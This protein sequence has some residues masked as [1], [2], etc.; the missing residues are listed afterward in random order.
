MS[1]QDTFAERNRRILD[2]LQR[3]GSLTVDEIVTL[4][5]VSVATVRRDLDV[6]ERDGR[7]RRT[8]GGAIPLEPLLYQAF[9]HDSSFQEQVEH[10]SAEKRR[11][12]L[13]AAALIEEGELIAVTPGTTAMQVTR[14]IPAHK[15]ITVLTNTVNI[16][17]EL[18]QRPD[19]KVI[20]TGGSLRPGWFSLVGP[21][22]ASSVAD[23]VLDRL[24]I[25]VNGVDVRWGLTAWDEGEAQTNAAL[26]S[27]ARHR[28]L[29]AD[30][31][32]LGV[33]ATHCFGKVSDLELLITDSG[34]SEKAI[35][36]F[37]KAGV[38]VRCV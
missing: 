15:S 8:H 9:R 28:I 29:V 20:V 10:H 7:L 11:I 22:A 35:R 18:S 17:M 31:S 38:R 19:V 36:P 6:L 3:R 30:H 37:V 34:A 2:E 4:L 32:K 21:H 24:F 16:P 5:H 12:A 13:A 1:K 27:R 23:V 26:L 33:A 25:G 14:N